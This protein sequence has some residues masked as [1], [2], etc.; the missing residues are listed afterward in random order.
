MTAPAWRADECKKPCGFNSHLLRQQTY[1][2]ETI[3]L[4]EFV[5]K[6]GSRITFQEIRSSTFKSPEASLLVIEVKEDPTGVM[7]TQTLSAKDGASAMTRVL[8]NTAWSYKNESSSQASP[9]SA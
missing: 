1:G 9:P 5:H 6:D 3:S 4:R 7:T 2:M 8:G